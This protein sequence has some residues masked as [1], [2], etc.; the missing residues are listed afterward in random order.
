MFIPQV[1]VF[2]VRA[3]DRP[4]THFHLHIWELPSRPGHSAPIFI[5][6]SPQ[7]LGSKYARVTHVV[8]NR[9]IF[10]LVRE[11]MKDKAFSGEERTLRPTS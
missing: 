2:Q 4:S 6:V 11:F 1:G 8:L 7:N 3:D 5:R 10:D 9:S